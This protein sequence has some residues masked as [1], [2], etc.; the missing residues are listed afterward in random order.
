MKNPLAS[1]KEQVFDWL[2]S[3]TPPAELQEMVALLK[4]YRQAHDGRTEPYVCDCRFC[5]RLEE[6]LPREKAN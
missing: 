5:T 1:I 2:K 3:G 4:G 6:I